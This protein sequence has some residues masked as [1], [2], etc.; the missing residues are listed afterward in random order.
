VVYTIVRI[1]QNLLFQRLETLLR[2][3]DPHIR[4]GQSLNWFAR[5]RKISASLGRSLPK[6]LYTHIHARSRYITYTP[7][8]FQL[9][10]VRWNPVGGVTW[11]LDCIGITFIIL[12]IRV[13]STVWRGGFHKLLN[14]NLERIAILCLGTHINGPLFLDLE[15]SY[16]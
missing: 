3:S 9:Q 8:Q 10:Q 2:W 16:W 7:R 15:C 4:E 13:W 12:K 1:L 6:S 14:F 5:R 11:R